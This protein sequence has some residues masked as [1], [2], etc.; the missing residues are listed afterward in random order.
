MAKLF[1]MLKLRADLCFL[2]KIYNIHS[3]RVDSSMEKDEK[4]AGF[5]L[6]A[7]RACFHPGHDRG[8][9]RDADPHFHQRGGGAG[10]DA[11]GKAAWHNMTDLN[12]R[13]KPWCM[14]C[15][16]LWMDQG[17]ASS[18]VKKKWNYSPSGLTLMS[19]NSDTDINNF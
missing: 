8:W 11:E 3:C 6:S 7:C 13:W 5:L 9:E 10:C 19:L 17:D 18:A 15:T 2:P 14:G 4:I 1:V 12:D 16:W